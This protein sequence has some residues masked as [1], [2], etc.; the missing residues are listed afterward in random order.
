M[1]SFQG[2]RSSKDDNAGSLSHQTPESTRQLGGRQVVSLFYF[3]NTITPCQLVASFLLHF[4]ATVA[5]VALNKQLSL[6]VSASPRV[7]C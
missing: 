1:L 3:R 2:E 7:Y 5:V 6:S 4:A